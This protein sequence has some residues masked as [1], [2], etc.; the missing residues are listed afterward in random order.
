MLTCLKQMELTFELKYSI[1]GPIPVSKQLLWKLQ[2][3]TSWYLRIF[4]RIGFWKLNCSKQPVIVSGIH[5]SFEQLM[6]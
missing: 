6:N 2:E 5:L 1:S 3:P 4:V